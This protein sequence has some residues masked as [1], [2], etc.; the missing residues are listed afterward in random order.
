LEAEVLLRTPPLIERTSLVTNSRA[1]ARLY[2]QAQDLRGTVLRYG[3]DFAHLACARAAGVNDWRAQQFGKV[4][5]RH[6]THYIRCY[7]RMRTEFRRSRP[8]CRAGNA[9]DDEGR[10]RSGAGIQYNRAVRQAG[11]WF[12]VV[13]L[14]LAAISTANAQARNSKLQSAVTQAMAGERGAAVVLDVHTG[15][16]LAAYHAEVAARRVVLPGSAIK[17]F[18]LLALLQTGSVDA[19]TALVCQR[20]LTIAGHRLDCLHPNTKEPLGPA[21]ALAYSCNSWFT[22]VAT[23]L[24]AQQLRDSFLRDGFNSATRL[25][26]NEASGSV[27]LAQSQEQLQLEAIGEW[28]ISVTPLQLLRAYR[29]LALLSQRNTEARVTALLFEGL[30]Q[31]VSYGM[32]SAAQPA[33]PMKVAGKTGTSSADEG[34]WTHGWFAGY[35]PAEDPEIVLVVFLEKG[36]GSDAAALASKIFSAFA[37]ERDPHLAAAAARPGR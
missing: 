28:G 25:E 35:A 22:S 31:S 10:L 33:S 5:S 3:C 20:P 21:A 32:A 16:L 13:A 27:A 7:R 15:R 8:S 34:P 24:T 36:R 19:H 9:L 1:A 6:R 29:Q 2:Y 26:P 4:E 14:W 11:P 23:R 37:E 12:A 17:P 30:Q 18:T